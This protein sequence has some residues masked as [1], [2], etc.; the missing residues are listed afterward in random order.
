LLS[1]LLIHEHEETE[2]SCQAASY[3]R[4]GAHRAR[5]TCCIRFFATRRGDCGVQ[6]FYPFGSEKQCV[7]SVLE[8]WTATSDNYRWE[9]MHDKNGGTCE[10]KSEPFSW[11]VQVH[12]DMVVR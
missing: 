5:L 7:A 3:V 11:R 10:G 2:H 6:A 4:H 8:Q 12:T 9:F 1:G